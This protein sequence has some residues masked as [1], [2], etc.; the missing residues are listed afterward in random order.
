MADADEAHLMP[1]HEHLFGVVVPVAVPHVGGGQ[2]RLRAGRVEA[3]GV[4]PRHRHL[5]VALPARPLHAH[6][7]A[8]RRRLAAQQTERH[9][10]RHFC[11]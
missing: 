2:A 10:L 5:G 11:R 1:I 6:E 9:A 8:A 7:L 3:G 4:R